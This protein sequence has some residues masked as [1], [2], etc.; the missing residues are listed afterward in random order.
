MPRRPCSPSAAWTTRRIITLALYRAHLALFVNL[1]KG[2]AFPRRKRH[3]VFEV[4]VRHGRRVAPRSVGHA[5]VPHHEAV[6]ELLAASS[7]PALRRLLEVPPPTVL[8]RHV[9]PPVGGHAAA[10]LRY[11]SSAHSN[12]IGRRRLGRV[13]ALRERAALLELLKRTYLVRG[14]ALLPFLRR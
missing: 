9:H 13:I 5:G 6:P 1:L 10:A 8:D 11:H 3:A 2:H 4:G 7:S 14:L 12:S